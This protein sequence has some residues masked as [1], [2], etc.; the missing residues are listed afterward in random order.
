MSR[1]LT[2][3]II[4][5]SIRKILAMTDGSLSVNTNMEKLGDDR[6][7]ERMQGR[8]GDKNRA[9]PGERKRRY[10]EKEGERWLKDGDKRD[11]KTNS[12]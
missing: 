4:I 8:D 3:I 5:Q 1:E 6:D 7:E 11:R 9:E 2:Q 10:C 12:V